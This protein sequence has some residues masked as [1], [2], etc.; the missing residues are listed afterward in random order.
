VEVTL[1]KRS[2][3]LLIILLIAFLTGCATAGDL[4][5][6]Q[7]DL[8]TKISDHDGKVAAIQTDTAALQKEAVQNAEAVADIRKKQA[9]MGAD[10]TDIRE[11][12]QRLQGTVDKLQKDTDELHG[13]AGKDFKE[14][15]DQ[16]TFK[17]NF[18]ENFLGI[19]KKEERT[20]NG[21]KNNNKGHAKNGSK[22]KSDKESI[23]AAAYELYKEGKY[24]KART[25]FQNFLKAYPK[26]EYSGNA[27]FW[28]GECY[29]Y[30]K[31][32]EKAILEYEKVIKTYPEGNKVPQALLKQ[33]LSFL[34]LKD[35]ASAK[36]ILQNIIKDYPNTTQARVARAKLLEI[37]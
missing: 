26:T 18:I 3:R 19:G 2:V 14:R 6:V 32:Y 25:E 16:A 20:E 22:G 13:P 28:I 23:Y 4:K 8:G 15:L 33:G 37:K 12:I 29:Y 7:G 9:D 1:L 24:E 5:R 30:E 10:L 11:Q 36:L 31:S 34:Q 17:I 35:K 21:E 27:Q